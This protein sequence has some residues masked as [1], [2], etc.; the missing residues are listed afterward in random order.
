MNPKN[1]LLL[2]K[3]KAKAKSS[4]FSRGIKV[5]IEED[6]SAKVELEKLNSVSKEALE[7]IQ[8]QAELLSHSIQVQKEQLQNQK[9]AT[10]LTPDPIPQLRKL[11]DTIASSTNLISGKLDSLKP[12]PQADNTETL[13]KELQGVKKAVEANKLPT[14]AKDAIAVRLT[15][16]EEFY[17]AVTEVITQGFGGNTINI[18]KVTVSGGQ[19][20]IPVVNPDG[21]NISAGGSVTQYTDGTNG[22]GSS[23]GTVA[24]GAGT[25]QILK[26]IPL[27]NVNAAVRVNIVAGTLSVGQNGTWQV[28]ALS[29]ISAMGHGVKTVSAAGTD[30]ALSG[31]SVPCKKVVIQAQTDNTGKIA[32]GSSGVDATVATGTGVLLEPGDTFELEMSDLMLIYID[33]TVN[34][35]GVRYTYF[36]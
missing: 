25:D 22:G 29:P 32:V 35:D 5:S 10:L 9:K 7:T 28:I 2:E 4:E 11:S 19:Q 14:K 12:V 20:A 18:P 33:S 23:T 6:K 31:S 27:D 17:K 30:E 15:D 34:G 13:V 3:I 36:A 8:L 26:P 1:R 16:G 21:T 24:L